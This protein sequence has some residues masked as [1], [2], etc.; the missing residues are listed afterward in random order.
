MIKSTKKLQE[1]TY[2]LGKDNNLLIA[3]TIEALRNE[4]PFE[5]AIGSLVS[6]YDKTNDTGTRKTIENFLND[7][8]DLS[9][10]EEVIIEIG[11]QWKPR[12]ISMLVASCWQSGLDYSDYSMEFIMAFLNGDYITA[13]ECMTVIEEF[14]HELTRE[15]RHEMIK[16]ID[17]NP[18]SALNEKKP[19]T[20]ELLMILH[21]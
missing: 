16:I 6:Y 12:T 10:R 3:D 14:A 21:R 1:L 2:V 11:K 17:Q 15:K 20:D 5:G 19:L 8:K 9:A 4:Q 18:L 7:V 13:I